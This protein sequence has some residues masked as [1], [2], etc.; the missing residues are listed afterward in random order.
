MVKVSGVYFAWITLNICCIHL[1]TCIHFELLGTKQVQSQLSCMM[2]E[3]RNGKW[4][5]VFK[6][7]IST[8][9]RMTLGMLRAQ[10]SDGTLQTATR[11]RLSL[12]SCGR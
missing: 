6:V 12:R 3:I 7:A 2:I 1:A 9:A 8:S 5:A 4:N 11:A 10:L